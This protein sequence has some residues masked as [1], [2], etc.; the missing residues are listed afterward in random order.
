L[1][2][3]ADIRSRREITSNLMVAGKPNQ[4]AHAAGNR[5]PDESPSKEKLTRVSGVAH[6]CRNF[7]HA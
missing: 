2:T 6:S 3:A 1:K 4:A 5:K 7:I